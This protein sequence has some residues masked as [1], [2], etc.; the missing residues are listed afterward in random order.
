MT[1]ARNADLGGPLDAYRT[2]DRLQARIAMHERFGNASFDLHSWIFDLL[3]NPD[4]AGPLVPSAAKVLEVGAGTGRM[5]QVVAGQVPPD[6]NLTLTDRSPGML[7]ALRQ[8]TQE[9]GLDASVEEADASA[10]PYPDATFDLAFANHMLYHLP[11]PRLGVAELRRVLKP[12]GLLVA[13]TNGAGHMRQATDLVRPL[14]A[15][16]GLQLMGV[17][18]L[19]F[20]CESGGVTLEERFSSVELRRQDDELQVTDLEVLL[21][22]LR[23][24]I[25]LPA[26]PAPATVSALAEWEASVRSLPLPFA[27]ER[28][29]G[30]FFARA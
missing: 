12:G 17:E 28:A 20:T 25:H 14:A 22:Y 6:W 26:Q 15:L 9:L 2:T 18:P 4:A 30:V 27:V 11:D 29:T 8:P 19:S 10:L 3:M 1:D 21:A 13:A 7:E 16:E 23:S 24:L 5:W